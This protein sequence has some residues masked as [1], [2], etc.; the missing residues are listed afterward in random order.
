M[1]LKN[2]KAKEEK[3]KRLVTT[4]KNRQIGFSSIKTDF[5]RYCE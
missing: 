4:Y 3:M 1:P 2:K 5:R